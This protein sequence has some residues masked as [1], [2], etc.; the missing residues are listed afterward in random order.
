MAESDDHVRR[1]TF[2]A[3]IYGSHV[4]EERE[5]LWQELPG[6]GGT[7]RLDR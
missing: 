6:K 3:R 5:A 4:P 2:L 1:E 7:G